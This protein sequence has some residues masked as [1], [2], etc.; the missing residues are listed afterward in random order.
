M[1][2]DFLVLLTA[3]FLTGA[4]TGAFATY[5]AKR[6]IPQGDAAAKRTRKPRPP[7]CYAVESTIQEEKPPRPRKRKHPPFEDE[8]PGAVEPVT[9]ADL[10]V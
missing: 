8:T 4:V 9:G 10:A 3:T 2:F 6:L 5:M 7:R 1:S